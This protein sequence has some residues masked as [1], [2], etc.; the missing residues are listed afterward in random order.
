MLFGPVALLPL[1]VE[2][3]PL[4]SQRGWTHAQSLVVGALLAPGRRTV[5]AVLRVMGRSQ[6][7]RFQN[8]QR[9]LNRAQWAS[10]ARARVRLGMVVRPLLPVGPV[11]IGIAD[12][13]ERRRGEKR[14]AKGI[15]RD[16]VRSSHSPMVKASGRR[17]LCATL[18]AEVPWAGRIGALP[19]LTALCPSE[20]SQQ[21]RG[22]PHKALPAWAGQLIGLSH[23]WL[24][25][26]E[27]IVVADS[28]YAVLTLL[29]QGSE[30]PG[31]SL[32]TRLRLDAAR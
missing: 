14:K 5:T 27:V 20:R 32:I 30:L 22:R 6:E 24:P 26:R 29:K 3:A 21:Q 9:V 23:R 25:R 11:V 15:Y 1:S 2:F 8:Y 12:T 16:P 18:L 19:F 10:L 13:L 7:R 17:W 28:S 31:V 4:F